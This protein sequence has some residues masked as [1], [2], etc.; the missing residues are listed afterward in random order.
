MTGLGRYGIWSG[1]IGLATTPID[2]V[3]EFAREV[4][5]L[6]FDSLWVPE[7]FGREIFGHAAILLGATSRI[8]IATGIA[9]MYARDAVAMRNGARTLSEAYPGRFVLGVGVSHALF[10][11]PRGHD[12]ESPMAV[13]TRYLESM[14]SARWIGPEPPDVPVLLGALGPRMIELAGDRIDGIHPYKV[15]P[16]HTRS[17][18]QIVGASKIVAPEQAVA[19]SDDEAAA[20]AAAREH[21]RVYLR[22]D[23]Y[24]RSFLRQGFTED[25]LAERGSDRIVDAIVAHGSAAVATDRIAAHL[26]AGADH[27]AIQAIPVGDDSALDAVRRVAAALHLEGV[28][29]VT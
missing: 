7:A 25:D 1:S 26:D 11:A 17:A 27:V 5:R 13:A 12:Y 8:T 10:V 4:E 24:R 3:V 28:T 29:V 9:N 18:R 23:N 15:T 22:L 16:E 19:I 20:R 2:E 21:F 14:E 6:G